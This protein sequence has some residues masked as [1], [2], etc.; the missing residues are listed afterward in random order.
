MLAQDFIRNLEYSSGQR[1]TG[2]RRVY[3]NLRGGSP[4][5]GQQLIAKSIGDSSSDL[6][7]FINKN[8]EN[9]DFDINYKTEVSR[10]EKEEER[11]MTALMY[12]AKNGK[13]R[14]VK[15]LL[16]NGA[17]IYNSDN[18]G[19]TALMHAVMGGGHVEVVKTLLKEMKSKKGEKE[20]EEL[21]NKTIL[22]GRSVG[23]KQCEPRTV[24]KYWPLNLTY[25]RYWDIIPED[26]YDYRSP[27]INQRDTNG[28]TALMHAAEGN[29][30][31]VVNALLKHGADKNLKANGLYAYE[32]LPE[33]ISEGSKIFRKLWFRKE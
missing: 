21:C 25:T 12:A 7:E 1:L 10:E 24:K 18:F 22:Q 9:N 19:Q 8:K 14:N 2:L 23:K 17:T 31:K 26:V 4:K 6:E 20:A 5:V 30:L 27:G 32:M 16:K 28:Q 15:I 13:N 3:N 29:H 11:E 33:N